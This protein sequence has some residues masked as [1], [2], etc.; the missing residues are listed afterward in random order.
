MRMRDGTFVIARSTC[1]EAIQSVRVSL[2]CFAASGC[3]L[4][5]IGRAFARPV[6]A[7][8]LGSQ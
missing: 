1:D 2:D 8:P 4:P 3:A 7:D 6:G 5:V